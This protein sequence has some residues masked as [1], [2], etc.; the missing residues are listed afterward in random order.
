MEQYVVPFKANENFC[1][2]ETPAKVNKIPLKLN[3]SQTPSFAVI[4][5]GSESTRNMVK[6]K[7]GSLNLQCGSHFL[8]REMRRPI[9][10]TPKLSR[11][12]SRKSGM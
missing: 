2:E 6:T 9:P 4:M 10:P 7:G 1:F 3:D 11:K 5:R 8:V 12:I